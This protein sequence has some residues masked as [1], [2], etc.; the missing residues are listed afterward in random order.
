MPTTAAKE[1]DATG[2]LERPTFRQRPPRLPGGRRVV[3]RGRR[4]CR[5]AD[6][7]IADCRLSICRI[8]SSNGAN[9]QS[10]IRNLAMRASACPPTPN[11]CG[12]PAARRRA[13]K[14][15]YPWD[16]PGSGRV[17][18]SETEEAGQRSWRGR[19][20]LNPASAARRR[21]RCIRWA[22]A[23]RTGLWDVAGNVWEWIGSWY[24]K[25]QRGRVLRGGSWNNQDMPV[26]A[27]ARDNP[28]GLGTRFSFGLPH[29]SGS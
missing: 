20:R 3:V 8:V 13:S 10:E 21:W 27:S 9:P 18:D 23:S 14:E 7:T 12:W 15:R 2:I 4:V 24:D 28:D 26:P 29:Y 5:V 25:E 22:R 6:G 11:G 17:T 19:T 16:V 1:R